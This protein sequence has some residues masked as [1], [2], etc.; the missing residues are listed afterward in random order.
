MV[1]NGQYIFH[2]RQPQQEQARKKWS[3]AVSWSCSGRRSRGCLAKALTHWVAREG[4]NQPQPG[5]PVDL[6]GIWGS[7][8]HTCNVDNSRNIFMTDLKNRMK[9]CWL[10]NPSLKYKTVFEEKQAFLI[11]RI[12]SKDLRKKLRK[13]CKKGVDKSWFHRYPLKNVKGQKI[14]KFHK[15][16]CVF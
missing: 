15:R 9:Q 4:A 13:E 5:W 16:I 8:L 6:V 14:T 3:K 10:A 1:V 2:R 12:P 7:Q 11:S